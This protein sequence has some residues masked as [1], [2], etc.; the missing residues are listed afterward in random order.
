MIVQCS[1]YQWY[2][3]P[4]VPMQASS[5]DTLKGHSIQFQFFWKKSCIY[6]NIFRCLV[7]N[8]IVQSSNYQWYG[9]L[10]VPMQVL[11]MDTLKGHS[12]QFQHFWKKSC[13]YINIFRCLV[14]NIVYGGRRGGG[15]KL[16]QT[17]KTVPYQIMFKWVE[18]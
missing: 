17:T 15:D 14:S 7:S 3:H 16:P 2:G 11:S 5:M 10:E 8:M 18:K 6:I 12:I 9:H 4:E 1:N 13:I